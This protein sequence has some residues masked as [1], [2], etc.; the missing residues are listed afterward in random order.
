MNAV[1][2][3]RSR[4]WYF[5]VTVVHAER[6]W[7]VENCCNRLQWVDCICFRPAVRNIVGYGTVPYPHLDFSKLVGSGTLLHCPPIIVV[8]VQ[9]TSTCSTRTDRTDHLTAMT[10]MT[11]LSSQCLSRLFMEEFTVL[12][13]T[14][15]ITAFLVVYFSYYSIILFWI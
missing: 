3:E 9:C 13:I 15:S 7:K 5:V 12:L 4:L 6:W 1:Q 10:N 11:R 14:A 2:A 8:N